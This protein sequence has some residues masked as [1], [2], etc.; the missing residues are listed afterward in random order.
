MSLTP[1]LL[2]SLFAVGSAS[3]AVT[4][5]FNKSDA[6]TLVITV[7]TAVSYEMTGPGTTTVLIIKGAGS[8]TPMVGLG[9]STAAFSDDASTIPL[10]GVYFTAIPVQGDLDPLDLMLTSQTI[11]TFGAGD[12]FTLSAGTI[13]LP[14]Y[15]AAAPA[16]GEYDSYLLSPSP[17][18]Y[19]S[20]VG[21]AVPE[22]SAALLAGL[23]STALLRRRRA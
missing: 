11:L 5:T 4:L 8:V 6:N 16:D 22:P 17:Q 9:S 15:T 12:I 2:A 7:T 1:I 13:T 14:N 19:I 20:T 10:N 3:A 21:Q 18:T 23:A